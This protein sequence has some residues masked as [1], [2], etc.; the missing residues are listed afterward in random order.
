[1]EN[2]ENSSCAY[3]HSTWLSIHVPF[4]PFLFPSQKI[5]KGDWFLPRLNIWVNPAS[6]RW[7]GF[8]L[9]PALP[10][11]GSAQTFIYKCC[12]TQ[13]GQFHNYFS[14]VLEVPMAY[15]VVPNSICAG[16]KLQSVSQSLNNWVNTHRRNF[17]FGSNFVAVVMF[18]QCYVSWCVCLLACLWPVT[19]SFLPDVRCRRKNGR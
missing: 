9:L 4:F 8:G 14:N 16:F 15:I 17:E 19:Q 13:R 5:T 7:R 3:L 18:L 11:G 10:C 12:F 1:M 2:W 6:E